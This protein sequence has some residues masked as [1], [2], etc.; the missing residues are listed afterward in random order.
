[1]FFLFNADIQKFCQKFREK[2]I[3]FI[4]EIENDSRISRKNYNENTKK[5]ITKAQGFMIFYSSLNIYFRKTY[6]IKKIIFSWC[7]RLFQCYQIKFYYYDVFLKLCNLNLSSY[8]PYFNI[9]GVDYEAS[10]VTI[11]PQLHNLEKVRKVASTIA[12]YCSGIR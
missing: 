11:A 4:F 6:L 8:F 2:F 7:F 5:I 12:I 1:M 3:I 9:D 10:W